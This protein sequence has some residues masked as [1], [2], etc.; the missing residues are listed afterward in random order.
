MYRFK[1]PTQISVNITNRCNLA[2]T[3]C[4]NNSGCR[5]GEEMQLETIR[6]I[7]DYM[8]ERGIV[9][10]DI[11]GGEPFVHPDIKEIL[12][13]AKSK[14]LNISIATNGTLLNEEL[15]EILIEV[16]ASVRI[17]VDGIDEISYSAMRGDNFL[18]VINNIKL[19]ISKGL[20]PTMVTC[21]HEGNADC[22]EKF[23][24]FA[25]KLEV[26]QL[27]LLPF[28]PIG[29]GYDSDFKIMSPN[30]W[31]KIL[32][33]FKDFEKKYNIEVAIDSP[34]QSIIE[35]RC[36]PCMVGKLYLVIKSNGDVI[37]CSLLDVVIGNIY[38]Q[39]IDEIWQQTIID[40]FNDTSLLKECQ[41]CKYIEMCSGGCR[42]LSN[43]IK[44]NYLCKDPLC[45]L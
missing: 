22:V 36:C 15:I 8:S 7:V 10:F 27:R 16:E 11:S 33:S 21:I 3:H 9:C 30:Q 28:A 18:T 32:A 40:K 34:M 41:E 43:L 14:G 35:N 39:T 31:H 45:W 17:S 38:Y 29:R 4:M 13:Y 6:R 2:C 20:N 23:V 44:G 19:A 42:G 24:E 25:K 12:K 26:H 1:Y 5:V 37:P